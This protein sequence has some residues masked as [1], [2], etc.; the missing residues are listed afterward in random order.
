[1]VRA[2]PGNRFAW[3]LEV[4]AREMQAL[5]SDALWR[6]E[7]ARAK[8]WLA[9]RESRCEARQLKILARVNAH[10]HFAHAQLH[11]REMEADEHQDAEEEGALPDADLSL[12]FLGPVDAD[13]IKSLLEAEAAGAAAAAE[14]PVVVQQQV[15][16]QQQHEKP[17]EM[18][19]HLLAK[20][21]PP[22]LYASIASAH[23]QPQ[24]VMPAM[25]LPAQ[26]TKK[27]SVTALASVALEEDAGV[28]ELMNELELDIS[29]V[30]H[31]LPPVH[32]SS[33][34]NDD[35][36]HKSEEPS[37]AAAAAG[38]QRTS[39]MD[40]LA[41]SVFQTT[42]VLAK[43]GRN[44][45]RD[46][47]DESDDGEKTAQRA[48]P[49]ASV[50][51]DSV[52]EEMRGWVTGYRDPEV[53]RRKEAM[54]RRARRPTSRFGVSSVE[55]QRSIHR[56][57]KY[58]AGEDADGSSESES[59]DST[60]SDFS[61]A[62]DAED[63]DD[64]ASEV[65][66]LSDDYL[67]EKERTSKSCT[68]PQRRRLR[69]KHR[70]SKAAK[71]PKTRQK[72]AKNS[73]KVAGVSSS[74]EAKASPHKASTKVNASAGNT[75]SSSERGAE[76]FTHHRP[77]NPDSDQEHETIDL[78][79]S[80]EAVSDAAPA[81]PKKDERDG[82]GADNSRRTPGG[83]TSPPSQVK[84]AAQKQESPR[85]I[86]ESQRTLS[87][88][89]TIEKEPKVVHL[90]N[91]T[92][93]S[94]KIPK[95][96]ETARASQVA[97]E[98]AS[99]VVANAVRRAQPCNS[100]KSSVAVDLHPP[101]VSQSTAEE[102]KPRKNVE[103]SKQE[104][105]P[106]A[107]AAKGS[108]PQALTKALL[109]EHTLRES[110]NAKE[111]AEANDD[112]SEADTLDF[113]AI[114]EMSDE[115]I[116]E[117]GSTSTRQEDLGFSDDDH[118]DDDGGES[119]GPAVIAPNDD[120][121][122]Q[123]F[124]DTPLRKQKLKEQ[125]ERKAAEASGNAAEAGK[126]TT[127]STSDSKT[128]PAAQQGSATKHSATG[129]VPPGS[130]P[131]APV[132][133]VVLETTGSNGLRKKTKSGTIAT[134]T[135]MKGKYQQTRRSMKVIV[136][137]NPGRGK[138][139]VSGI[140]GSNTSVMIGVKK[141]RF[142][143]P[144]VQ[145]P[146]TSTEFTADFLSSISE[147][148]L[149]R[150]YQRN[151]KPA[152]RIEKRSGDDEERYLSYGGKK[153]N[154]EKAVQDNDSDDEPLSA[155]VRG[156]K[157]NDAA[158]RSSNASKQDV[159]S[160]GWLFSSAVASN[161]N[162]DSNPVTKAP[163]FLRDR[164][165]DIYEALHIEGRAENGLT[166]R[167]LRDGE[168]KRPS[169]FKKVQEEREKR[170]ISFVPRETYLEN[171]PI[172]KKKKL[173]GQYQQQSSAKTSSAKPPSESRGSS[174]HNKRSSSGKPSYTEKA[175]HYGPSSG[176]EPFFSKNKSVYSSNDKSF[177]SK[178]KSSG[179]RGKGDNF[180]A[181]RSY[182]PPSRRRS[183]D[184][185]RG[186]G[187]DGPRHH[188]RSRSPSPR[189]KDRYKPSSDASRKR[190]RSTSRS[191][192]REREDRSWS[193]KGDDRDRSRSS[194]DARD[195]RDGHRDKS[196]P[197]ADRSSSESSKKRMRTMERAD[198]MS[199][200][201]QLDDRSDT[202][203]KAKPQDPRIRASTDRAQPIPSSPPPGALFEEGFGSDMYISDSDNENESAEKA[204]DIRFNLESVQVDARQLKRRVYVTG[205]TA[206]M[207]E[208]ELEELFAPFGIE[209]RVRYMFVVDAVGL[210]LTM[211]VVFGN[212]DR[213]RDR[214]P[215]DRC[216]SLSALA[217][218]AR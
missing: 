102:A 109:K 7:L 49:G 39:A 114:E 31:H 117:F 8:R 25:R 217:S 56:A 178:G 91:D 148:A 64:P 128:T 215:S 5:D 138:R 103:P 158:G 115:P 30:D 86:N 43:K 19:P 9:A 87:S 108:E 58:Y 98:Q 67:E 136:E 107:N 113:D 171:L 2:G 147:S 181:R 154:G 127:V 125:Q 121:Y 112:V 71:A 175:S 141:S 54:A 216:V 157:A 41:R 76:L 198:D 214:I 6:D 15:P 92:K 122:E 38:S 79:S 40:D 194:K 13:D 23:L 167:D 110:S 155:S 199:L 153:P 135:V 29:D 172:P 62:D 200:T 48:R 95:S 156:A 12:D 143:E 189:Q 3:L 201:S 42:I 51:P 28:A 26:A 196:P 139:S 61:P 149:D 197:T 185:D 104:S 1:M 166:S 187:K 129:S 68:K 159:P 11:K 27:V 145:G 97:E 186:R 137:E 50:D 69:N 20:N 89:P 65:E 88:K 176:V 75:N 173:P 161:E 131:V 177:N 179:K 195:D 72:K 208:E 207:S 46:A 105:E 133:A 212:A 170:G 55:E 32:A 144:L 4:A 33:S 132:A 202:P 191:R 152:T 182:S 164:Q 119:G 174:D 73:S 160:K 63:R 203:K 205:M 106:P 180:N 211:C 83:F 35:E 10:V 209:V 74:S 116:Y 53:V 22:K 57:A 21:S 150:G 78:L 66:L 34:N 130:V 80:D 45:I 183:D 210:V 218:A 59:E 123:F 142:S 24:F 192:S 101:P 16:V 151:G 168:Y 146:H 17:I 36:E 94:P 84:P 126:S 14:T 206:M 70:D 90:K 213:S 93:A 60:G 99:V 134:T 118:D 47:S 96:A 85:A 18:P 188:T 111:P 140:Y 37:R 82:G 163:E 184:F 77:S 193:R 44:V 204:V 190:H 100:A 120:E 52:A 169:A 124:A 81:A 165:I 162:V